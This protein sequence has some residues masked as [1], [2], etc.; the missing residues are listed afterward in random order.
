MNLTL[1]NTHIFHCLTNTTIPQVVSCELQFDEQNKSHQPL[2]S[3]VMQALLLS[4]AYL[5]CVIIIY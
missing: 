5:N 3:S 1:D 4:N 2:I